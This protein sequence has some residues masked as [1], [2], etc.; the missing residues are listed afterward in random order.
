MGCAQ[1]CWEVV[2]SKIEED[3][4]RELKMLGSGFLTLE[5]MIGPAQVSKLLRNMADNI[6]RKIDRAKP[7]LKRILEEIP[8]SEGRKEFR[9]RYGL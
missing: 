9:S 1:T 5:E 7:H 3:L 4:E 8:S 2:M 6:D